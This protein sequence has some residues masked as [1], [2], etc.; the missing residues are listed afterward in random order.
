MWLCQSPNSN[1]CPYDSVSTNH[2]TVKRTRLFLTFGLFCY[3]WAN[4]VYFLTCLILWCT[5]PA[6]TGTGTLSSV[7]FPRSG[8]A[9][10]SSFSSWL[11]ELK[12]KKKKK[13][14]DHKHIPDPCPRRR[15][16]LEP[17]AFHVATIYDTCV[18]LADSHVNKQVHRCVFT[19]NTR[20]WSN[21]YYCDKLLR[22]IQVSFSS[23]LLLKSGVKR[24]ADCSLMSGGFGG[25]LR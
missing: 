10:L 9:F 3:T 22:M 8:P 12:K 13:I 2:T 14:S 4:G 20:Y 25:H 6:L 23:F 21:S 11:K 7:S 1:T 5:C 16:F 15:F 24:E 19:C 18:V 17:D